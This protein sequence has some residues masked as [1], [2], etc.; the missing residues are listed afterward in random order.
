LKVHQFLTIGM[1]G[2][3]VDGVRNLRTVLCDCHWFRVVLNQ[4]SFV[5][6]DKCSPSLNKIGV[7][8]FVLLCYTFVNERG[9][10]CGH[11]IIIDLI[12]RQSKN[13]QST[14]SLATRLCP[15]HSGHPSRIHRRRATLGYCS[16]NFDQGKREFEEADHLQ[17]TPESAL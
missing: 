8:C 6:T 3:T 13:L 9:S 4:F 2:S 1:V 15:Q 14:D 5:S 12:C 17:G 7:R 11:A 10:Y 16:G